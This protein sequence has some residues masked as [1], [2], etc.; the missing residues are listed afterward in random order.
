MWQEWRSG[1]VG[2][3]VARDWRAGKG[4]PGGG[5]DWDEPEGVG[6]EDGPGGAGWEA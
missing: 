6:Q 3:G 1:R 5:A 2:R 4:V